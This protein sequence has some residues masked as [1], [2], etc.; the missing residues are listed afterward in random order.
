LIQVLGKPVSISEYR[1]FMLIDPHTL[2][3]NCNILN[4]Q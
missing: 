4:S 3:I 1:A 2:A